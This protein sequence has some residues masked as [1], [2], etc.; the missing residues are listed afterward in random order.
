M[1]LPKF[2]EKYEFFRMPKIAILF[3]FCALCPLQDSCL[4]NPMDRGAW[5]TAVHGVTK[6]QTRLSDFT[7]PPK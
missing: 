3:A 4:G 1:K 5:Q 7:S 6:S 2:L